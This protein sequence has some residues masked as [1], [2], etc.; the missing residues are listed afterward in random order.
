M[1]EEANN[2][3]MYSWSALFVSLSAIYAYRVYNQNKI[4]SHVCFV[5]FSLLAA[6]SHYFATFTI[7]LINIVLFIN[8]IK[9]K[10][11]TRIKRY[12][13]SGIIEIIL[14]IPG[15]IIFIYQFTRV[16]QSYWIEMHYPWI[17][18]NTVF[19]YFNLVKGSR[20]LNIMIV[21]VGILI[22]IC[23][24]KVLYKNRKDKNAKLAM[25]AILIYA[26][27]IV[28][29]LI[30]SIVKPIFVP[31][32]SFPMVALVI[33]AISYVLANIENQKIYS[34]MMLCLIF[35]SV[36]NIGKFYNKI[37]SRENQEVFQIVEENLKD[38]D[39][40]LY[41]NTDFASI[42]AN[43]FGTNKNIVYHLGANWNLKKVLE[44]DG[45]ELIENLENVNR[46]NRIW[47]LEDEERLITKEM[48]VEEEKIILQE[49]Y[50]YS[51]INSKI[52]ITLI[53]NQS[54]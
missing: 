35:I 37:Y 24:L 33:F 44:V 17:L 53:D 22:G 16:T 12:L 20:I 52:Y 41:N 49:E 45:V 51:Y 1:L 46:S 6:Y 14:F 40:L 54:L 18:I 34:I 7:V 50:F 8:Q 9:N 4:S 21:L 38:T 13:I 32:Y 42:Y 27:I 30:V 43:R 25:I 36:A 10:E 19:F 23:S 29:S 31:R 48:G 3:R 5:V 2:I 39:V 11:V 26:I 47:L 15:I 28:V